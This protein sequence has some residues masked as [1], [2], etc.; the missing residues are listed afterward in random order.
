[1]YNAHARRPLQKRRV[2]NGRA[3]NSQNR[4]IAYA[5]IT[6]RGRCERGLNEAQLRIGS[7]GH[8]DFSKWRVCRIFVRHDRRVSAAMKELVPAPNQSSAI[9]SDKSTADKSRAENDELKVFFRQFCIY[10][11]V[12]ILCSR[13]FSKTI[14]NRFVDRRANSRKA[15]KPKAIQAK[16]L[17]TQ[18]VCDRTAAKLSQTA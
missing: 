9:M 2:S 15:Q 8:W 1:M 3:S 7:G 6:T 18:V 14:S 16:S 5:T 17:S 13:I 11:R 10:I 12:S 4:P